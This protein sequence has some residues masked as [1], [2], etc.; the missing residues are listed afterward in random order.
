MRDRFGAGHALKSPAHITLQMP[1][2]MDEA[3]ERDMAK[4]LKNFATREMAFQ[5]DLNGFDSFPPRVLFVRIV[6]HRPL[7]EFHSRFKQT[8]VKELGLQDKSPFEY[9]PHMTIATRDLTEEAF[10][11]A[12]PEFRNRVFVANFLVKSLFLLKHN[13]K[14]WDVYKEFLFNGKLK[15]ES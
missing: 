11:L 9:H 8:V 4:S 6:N 12:W 13:G 2:R 10:N 1:F 3:Q 7:K 5:V 15:V 14:D